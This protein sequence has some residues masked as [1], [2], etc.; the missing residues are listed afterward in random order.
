MKTHLF[1]TLN[2]FTKDGGDTIRMKGIVNALAEA[3]QSVVLFSNAVETHYDFHISIKHIF[4][5]VEISKKQKIIFQVSIALL[6][7]IVTKF[8]FK[9]YLTVL[10]II[11]KKE[12]FRAGMP[13]IFFEYLDNSMA[14]FLNKQKIIGN[15]INDTH[16]SARLD[17]LHKHSNTLLEKFK[18]LSKC[19]IAI[20]LDRKIY[21][22]SS[23]VIFLSEAM[24]EYFEKYY[25]FIASNDNYIIRDGIGSGPC[26]Q[27][28]NKNNVD[29]YRR[30]FN[31]S[32]EDKVIM[33]AGTFK[34]SGGVFDLLKAFDILV[35]K[36]NTQN[37][38]LLLLGGGEYYEKIKRFTS[39]NHLEEKVIF[40]GRTSYSELRNYQ[41]LADVIVCPDKQHPVSELVPH[42]KYFDSLISGK[43]VING[44]FA[45]I[46]DINKDERFS[47]DFKPSDVNDL[48]NKIEMV[49]ADLDSFRLA[50]RFNHQKICTEFSYSNSVKV[51][52]NDRP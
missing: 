10:G 33:F 9:D 12:K 6:P 1:F 22:N 8:I 45:S 5:G 35:R 26:H 38:K 23:R 39:E 2:N 50:Y 4:L 17:F 34:D 14:L 36:K 40:A 27:I 24:K 46:R 29:K 52:I 7:S 51:L 42:I 16:G 3:G 31:I 49:L 44:S 48:S 28:I 20:I 15:Y 11:F 32:L 37:I 30:S 19:M 18:N 21:K 25:I 47:V 13:I 43:V 41:E